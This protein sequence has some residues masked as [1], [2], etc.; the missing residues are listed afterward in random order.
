MGEIQELH[1]PGPNFDLE[2]SSIWNMAFVWIML[3]MEG[4]LSG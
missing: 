1:R 3:H 2:Q 4:V